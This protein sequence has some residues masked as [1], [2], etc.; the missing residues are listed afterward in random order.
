MSKIIEFIAHESIVAIDYIQPVPIKRNVPEWY[1]KLSM[2]GPLNI[3]HCM[4]FLDTLTSGY[5][6]KSP[7]DYEYRHNVWDEKDQEYK[8]YW[9][10][11]GSIY[12]QELI[13]SERLN[14]NNGTEV[15][16]CHQIAGS[17]ML[18]KNRFLP[19][20]KIMNP[21][22][23]KTPPG[24]SCLFLPPMNNVDE[25]FSIIPGIVDTDTFRREVNFPF[26]I[27]CPKGEFVE[28]VIKVGTP[29]A[30]VFP[31]KRDS[32]KMKISKRSESK[33]KSVI[34]EQMIHQF[35][36]YKNK[37]WNKKQWS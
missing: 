10:Y 1:K 17:P 33:Y 30:Q 22:I 19:V 32:W 23:I 12:N 37:I 27:N 2:Q 20:H 9:E 16:G 4:P 34:V 8:T 7:I 36:H 18:E 24:Y 28:S 26:I 13:E 5:L 25:R 6:I 21:W 29:L 14:L 31:F 11:S 15:H 35:Q 3:K